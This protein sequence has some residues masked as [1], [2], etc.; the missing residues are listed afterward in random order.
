MFLSDQTFQKISK[1]SVFCFMVRGLTWFVRKEI[2]AQIGLGVR[3]A[4]SGAYCTQF[5]LGS[6]ALSWRP[7]K[8]TKDVKC[9]R[10]GISF[11]PLILFDRRTSPNQL[12]CLPFWRAQTLSEV[13]KNMI[14]LIVAKLPWFGGKK[15]SV[16]ISP[17]GCSGWGRPK[18]P[19]YENP[20]KLSRD[21]RF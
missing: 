12:S 15:I 14:F 8:H 4:S 9:E 6:N 11:W 2:S 13:I 16:S 7:V 3:D 20:E 5:D 17:I 18:I 21:N 10:Y 19:F 1:K